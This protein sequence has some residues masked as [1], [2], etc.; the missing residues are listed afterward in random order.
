MDAD[1]TVL[2]LSG[3]HPLIQADLIA[4]LTAAHDEA[5]AAAT[6]LTT[7]ELDPGGYGRTCPPRTA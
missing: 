4:G 7:E 6:L 5:G 3:D 2:V 1:A